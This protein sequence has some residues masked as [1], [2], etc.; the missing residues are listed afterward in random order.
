MIFYELDK[1]LGFFSFFLNIGTLTLS[2]YTFLNVFGF[3]ISSEVKK[4]IQQCVT[5][6]AK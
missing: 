3:V 4:F 6:S 1:V 2:F 5:E